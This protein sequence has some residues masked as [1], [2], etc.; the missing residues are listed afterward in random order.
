MGG[1]SGVEARPR[2]VVGMA[3]EEC[4][5]AGIRG[6]GRDFGLGGGGGGCVRK[7]NRQ[8]RTGCWAESHL[9]SKAECTYCPDPGF[10]ERKGS[11][12]Y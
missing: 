1:G 5:W 8:S 3:M 2:E 9:Q 4:E 7:I 12:N 6:G 10:K 11:T